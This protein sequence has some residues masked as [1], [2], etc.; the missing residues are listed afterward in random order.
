MTGP[1]PIPQ[2]DAPTPRRFNWRS[3]LLIGSLAVNLL[4]VGAAAA[5]FLVHESPG[6]MSGISEMQLI[7]RKFFGDLD[8]ARRSEMMAVFRGYRADFREGRE[9]RRVLA[10]ALADALAA[11]PY[12]EARMKSAIADF[13]AR[14]AH[15]VNRGGDAAMEFIGKLTPEE[16]VM[17][18]KRIRERVDGGRRE[19]DKKKD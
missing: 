4:F 6:R 10:A 18:S 9:S 15:L 16:R 19:R 11:D 13:N 8:S 17:L 14:S 3:A 2:P 5:R 1:D 12:D 7:P